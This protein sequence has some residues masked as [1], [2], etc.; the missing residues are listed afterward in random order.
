MKVRD[1]SEIAKFEASSWLRTAI[2]AAA[3]CGFMSVS[4][5]ASVVYDGVTDFSSTNSNGTWSYG[6]GVTGVPGTSFT[7]YTQESS[8]G[9]YPGADVWYATANGYNLPIVGHSAAGTSCC[10]TVVVP[11]N[12]LWMHPG[13]T[14]PSVDS[15]VK[16]TAPSSGTY[17]VS[18]FF[19]QL[20]TTGNGDGVTV[21]VNNNG[22]IKYSQTVGPNPP[23]PNEPPH[24]FS[25][26]TTLLAGQT[27]LF[28]VNDGGRGNFFYDS[29]GFD[30]TISAIPEASTWAMMI[31]GFFGVGFMAYRR[32]SS[33]QALR[34]A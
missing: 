27:I 15:I 17:S 16:W 3:A 31:L 24:A 33:G 14:P 34:L 7:N 9:I 5:Q 1:A 12:V 22:T 30:V 23:Y 28:G 10:G 26:T 21:L 18:G 13:A 25:Y 20:D 29:T 6:Y 19:E 8:N 32:K 11:N 4:A 2:I